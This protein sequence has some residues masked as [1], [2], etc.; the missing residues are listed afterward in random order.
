[1]TD[2]L[3]PESVRRY[4][5]ACRVT[6]GG[7]GATTIEEDLARTLLQAWEDLRSEQIRADACL[8]RAEAADA[9]IAR[10]HA[11]ERIGRSAISPG[12]SECDECTGCGHQGCDAAADWIDPAGVSWCAEH[13]DCGLFDPELA[14]V[15]TSIPAEDPGDLGDDTPTRV[16]LLVDARNDARQERDVGA[17]LLAVATDRL[18]AAEMDLDD[19][20]AQVAEL[21]HALDLLRRVIPPC[22]IPSGGG[23]IL[24]L[25]DAL[26]RET[27]PDGG[28]VVD[29][30]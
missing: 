28:E 23:L 14:A 26:L 15:L 2:P 9:E 20:R 19:A 16:S 22:Y 6:G 8:L 30:D 27:C 11:V 1:M 18:R 29:D 10:I 13:H 25:V 3:T 5:S 12:R 21:Q 4:L 17:Q 7:I 24:P